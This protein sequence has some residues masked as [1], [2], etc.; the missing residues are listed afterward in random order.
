VSSRAL[1]VGVGNVLRG[2]DGFGVAV[3][4]RLQ[5]MPEVLARAKV[6]ELG[7]GGVH[8]V[9]ELMDGYDLL[10]LVDAVDRGGDHGRLYVL[11]LD[12]PS[13]PASAFETWKVDL[14]DMHEAVP[15]KALVL[16]KALGVL[17]KRV[18]MVGCQPALTDELYIGLTAVVEAAVSLAVERVVAL[19]DPLEEL[20][21]RDEI[22][23]VMF[24]L[25]AEGLGP[26]ITV[27]DILRFLD[28]RTA[29]EHALTQLIEEQYMEAR[30]AA[31]E[32]RHYRLTRLGE[33]EGRRR[34]L[35]EFEPYLARHAHGECGTANCDCHSGGECR[36]AE[37]PPGSMPR[38]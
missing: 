32:S 1:V 10:V 28:D 11:D 19:L 38:V 35:D 24:W 4:K 14:T 20:K 6:V 21:R 27:E 33:R 22:L 34:F 7:I 29:V 3:V 37:D 2:D 16:A 15:E 31:R 23:Q 8:L 13:S 5:A 18:L 36:G 25:A 12:V 9:Q 30:G 17:P 26:D